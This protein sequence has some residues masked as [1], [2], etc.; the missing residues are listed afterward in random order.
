[1]TARAT[2]GLAVLAVLTAGCGSDSEPAAAEDDAT[3]AS[4]EAPP[5]EPAAA[6]DV[7]WE[8][9]QEYLA[10]PRGRYTKVH[11]VNDSGQQATI[12]QE[13][14][15]FDLDAS[16]VQREV[17]IPPDSMPAEQAAQFPDGL[18]FG[19]IQTGTQFL[20]SSPEVQEAC[21]TPWIDMT[22]AATLPPIPGLSEDRVGLLVEPLDVL[23]QAVG[24]PEHIETTAAGST[25]EITL[26]AAAGF[27][28]AA[29]QR[30]NPTIMDTL[31]SME[32]VAEVTLPAGGG[33]LEM[34]VDF[35]EVFGAIS[36]GALPAGVVV[37]TEWTV[38]PDVPAFDTT[39]PEV[40]DPSC[41]FSEPTEG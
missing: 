30:S 38:S 20:M 22:T 5:T 23:G 14:T 16:Y 19:I 28:L 17:K 18:T 24:E 13:T 4:S 11:G 32:T 6:E 21:G 27:T 10:A 31:N 7:P 40:A 3:A 12:M 1:V 35:T 37:R 8:A 9:L 36:G 34:S 41:F 39:V 33:A 25:Y 2:I 26:P 29:E 15:R